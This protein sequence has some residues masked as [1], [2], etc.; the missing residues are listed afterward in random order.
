[1]N[2]GDFI[3]RL[4]DRFFGVVVFYGLLKRKQGFPK[5]SVFL[6]DY[7]FKMQSFRV[8]GIGF[9][10]FFNIIKSFFKLLVFCVR[11]RS[12]EQHIEPETLLLLQGFG[13]KF[14]CFGKVFFGLQAVCLSYVPKGS[15]AVNCDSLVEV[16]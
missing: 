2:F 16:A 4:G 15:G 6:L 10:D 7:S 14:H 3:K 13:V 11:Q 5:V 12:L 8:Q 1:V 9:Q